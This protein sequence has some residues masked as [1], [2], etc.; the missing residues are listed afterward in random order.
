VSAALV[1]GGG[2]NAVDRVVGRVVGRVGVVERDVEG[3]LIDKEG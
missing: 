2:A 1:M 3:R